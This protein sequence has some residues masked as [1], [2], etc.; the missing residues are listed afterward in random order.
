M[1][2]LQ[3]QMRGRRYDGHHEAVAAVIAHA[4]RV[5]LD[6]GKLGKWE[7][8]ELAQAR[9]AVEI[10][11]LTLALNCVGKAIEVS[12]LSPEDYDSGFNYGKN[13]G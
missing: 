10:S 2:G 9:R 3:E 8:S 6:A 4:E 5:L 11:F 1:Y 13:R 7:R 12:Q